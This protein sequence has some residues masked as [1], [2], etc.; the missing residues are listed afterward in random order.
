MSVLMVL[1]PLLLGAL[2][3]RV[4][5][6]RAR[7]V[8]RPGSDK[9]VR[10]SFA[11]AAFGLVPAAALDAGRAGPPLGEHRLA[12]MRSVAFAV[13]DGD[14]RAASAYVAAAGEDWDARWSRTEFLQELATDGDDWLR[15]WRREEPGNAD[16]ATLHASLLVHRAWEVR[17]SG[18]AR[19]VGDER[20]RRFQEMLPEAVEVARAAAAL[21][22]RD[23]GPWVV[24]ITASRALAPSRRQFGELW[25]NL[26]ARAPYHYAGHWQALQYWCAKWHGSDRLMLRF[27]RRAAANAPAGSPLAGMYLHALHE[28]DERG[29]TGLVRARSSGS[30]KLLERVHASFALVGPEDERLPRL[31]HLLAHYLLATGN[32]DAALEQFRLLGRWCGAY[33][34]TEAADPVAAFDHARG[35]A[36]KGSSARRALRSGAAAKGRASMTR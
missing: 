24:M 10:E 30:R 18:Y 35:L 32:N 1:V 6:S 21:D 34:W 17:G 12:G 25:E 23:P 19:E 14:W 26:V 4:S 5:L 13:R 22:P 2:V 36:A 29:G 8:R 3:H 31:R 9:W 33:P 7:R 27:A 28:L 16:A 20:M 11:P 15:A